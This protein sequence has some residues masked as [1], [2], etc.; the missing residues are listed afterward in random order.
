MAMEFFLQMDVDRFHMKTFTG[1][2]VQPCQSNK[3]LFCVI[4]PEVKFVMKQCGHQS[5]GVCSLSNHITRRP[6]SSVDFEYSGTYRFLNGY[7]TILNAPIMCNTSGIIYVFKC[8]C[9]QY[10]Y[11]GESSNNIQYTINRHRI[12]GNQIIHNFLIG[13]SGRAN[14]NEYNKSKKIIH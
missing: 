14:S 2:N 10:E 11:V 1:G 13:G 9:G 6:Q 4:E 7:T 3:G 12:N 8:P 5:C